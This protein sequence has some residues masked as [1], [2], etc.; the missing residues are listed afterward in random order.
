MVYDTLAVIAI[1]FVAAAIA[2]ATN[3]GQKIA[4]H[5]WWF[6]GYLILAAYAYFAYCWRRGHTLG[7]RS[8]KIRITDTTGGPVTW[9]QTLIRFGVA[10]LGALVGGCGYWWVLFDTEGRAWHDR[11]SATRL[12]TFRTK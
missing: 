3:H 2:V 10:A 9:R 5:Q 12:T 7:M 1:W 11:V 6:S 8:W 4:P